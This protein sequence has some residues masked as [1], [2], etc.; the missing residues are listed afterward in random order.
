MFQ[1]ICAGSLVVL[2]CTD[3]SSRQ[4]VALHLLVL[5]MKCATESMGFLYQE[6][7]VDTLL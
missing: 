6:Y 5:S 1:K 4:K 2:L 7:E 3:D